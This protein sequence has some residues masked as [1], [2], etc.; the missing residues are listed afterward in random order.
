MLSNGG[1]SSVA[2]VH[3]KF[4]FSSKE[5]KDNKTFLNHK[6]KMKDGDRFT[7][8]KLSS[9]EVIE[10]GAGVGGGHR[11]GAS[12]LVFYTSYSLVFDYFLSTLNKLIH[13]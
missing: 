4:I 5:Q 8:K 9:V 11:H 6:D 1:T 7:V 12:G 13:V 2:V 10:E 3:H